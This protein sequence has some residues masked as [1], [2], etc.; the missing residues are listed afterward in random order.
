MLVLKS[1]LTPLYQRGELFVITSK[2]PPFVKGDFMF[3][4]CALQT[5]AD[6]INLQANLKYTIPSIDGMGFVTTEQDNS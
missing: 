4:L 6:I 5:K 2:S 1:P 3:R